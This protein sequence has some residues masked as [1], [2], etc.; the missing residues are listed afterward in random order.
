MMKK[1]LL[2]T[3]ALITLAVGGCPPPHPEPDIWIDM[4]VLPGD[5]E[6]YA[7]E[8][9]EYTVTVNTRVVLRI[10][11]PDK[12][13]L[14]FVISG[15][16]VRKELNPGTITAVRFIAR[17]LGQYEFYIEGLREKGLVGTLIVR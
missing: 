8:P 1:L 3:I 6:Y 15:L 12:I 11:N 10:H 13:P 4:P 2:T 17:E 14:I 5:P 9:D 16:N 7:F